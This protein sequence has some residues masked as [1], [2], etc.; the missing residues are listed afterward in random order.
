[1]EINHLKDVATN[2]ASWQ[3]IT[4]VGIETGHGFRGDVFSEVTA[5]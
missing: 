5:P 1:L 3:P 4:I 2:L